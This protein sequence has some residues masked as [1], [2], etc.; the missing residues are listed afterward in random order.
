VAASRFP[1]PSDPSA[2]ACPWAC[3][4]PNAV[5]I[6]QPITP[7][8]QHL[9]CDLEARWIGIDALATPASALYCQPFEIETACIQRAT[10]Q[11]C[12]AADD[13]LGDSVAGGPNPAGVYLNGVAVTPMIT[14]G[15]YATQT[16]SLMTDVTS[17]V[18]TGTNHLQL[19]NRDLGFV[20]SGVIYSAKLEIIECAVPAENTTWGEIKSLFDPTDWR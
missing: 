12:W 18:S 7:W 4:G 16:Q 14:G 6:S 8:I 1:L 3:D 10:L 11:I 19:Y 5:V 20:V 17:L 2:P 9:E 13:V 15:N